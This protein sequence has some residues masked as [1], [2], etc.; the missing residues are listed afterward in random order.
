MVQPQEGRRRGRRP[1]TST[2]VALLAGVSQKTV[3]RVFNDEPYVSAD[4]RERVLLAAGELG[5]RRNLAAATL[6][7][8][9]SRTIGVVCL[10]SSFWVPSALVIAIERAVRRAGYGFSTVNTLEGDTDGIATA[11]RSLLEQGVDGIV[12]SEPIDTEHDLAFVDA[13]ILSIGRAPEIAGPRLIVAGPDGIEGGAAATDYLLSLGHSTVF[14]IAGPRRWFSAQDRELGWRRS[15]ERAGRLVPDAIEGDW[16][17]ASGY[18]AGQR[19]ADDPRVTAVFAANDDMAIGLMRALRD[20]GSPGPQPCERGWVRRH[21]Y[22]RIRRPP[23][24]YRAAGF[25]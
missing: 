13:P 6:T 11:M 17:P 15:L 12:L 9:R 18:A 25:R 20:R 1:A 23:V 5:Y 16:S 19:L 10:G 14:H 2:D 7:R 4:L 21:P 8:G 22:R 3:S 24:D